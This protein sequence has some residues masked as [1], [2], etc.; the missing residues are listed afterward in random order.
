MQ[1]YKTNY[2]A[3]TKGLHQ[4]DPQQVYIYQPVTI[5]HHANKNPRTAPY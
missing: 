5:P 3:I 4:K 2:L 1:P